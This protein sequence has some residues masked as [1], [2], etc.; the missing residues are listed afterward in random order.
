MLNLGLVVCILKNKSYRLPNLKLKACIKLF[1]YEEKGKKKKQNKKNK[2]HP[3]KNTTLNLL[4]SLEIKSK[5]FSLSQMFQYE[6][7]HNSMLSHA[8]NA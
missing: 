5:I 7:M 1:F 6:R 4:R 3:P 2:N 8:H